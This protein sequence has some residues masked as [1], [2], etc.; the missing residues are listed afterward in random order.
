MLI[1]C[2]FSFII[3]LFVDSCKAR[4]YIKVVEFAVHVSDKNFLPVKTVR[5]YK[6]KV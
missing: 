2:L 5:I 4:L 6:L 3:Y 1:T